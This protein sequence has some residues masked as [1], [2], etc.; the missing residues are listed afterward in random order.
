MYFDMFG[1]SLTVFC[2]KIGTKQKKHSHSAV[3]SKHSTVNGVKGVLKLFVSGREIFVCYS[4]SLLLLWP[5]ILQR[6]C[7]LRYIPGKLPYC[8]V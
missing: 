4:L 5:W 7:Y 2:L 8:V 6:D 1:S 3:E